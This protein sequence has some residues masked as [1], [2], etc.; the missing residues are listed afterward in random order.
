MNQW[1]MPGVSAAYM[2]MMIDAQRRGE[3][4]TDRIAQSES[5]SWGFKRVIQEKGI[6][7]AC[8]VYIQ[9]A[10]GA[11]EGSGFHLGGGVIAT[12]AHVAPVELQG[13]PHEIAIT[14]DGQNFMPAS[15]ALSEADFDAALLVAP[16]AKNI[17][18]VELADSDQVQTGDPIAVVSSP[19]GWR[20]TATVGIVSNVKQSLGQYAPTKAWAEDLIF[21]DADILQGSSGGA[22]FNESGQVIGSIMGVTGM[23]AEEGIGQRAVAPSNRLRHLLRTYLQAQGIHL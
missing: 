18:M 22:V 7:S 8:T 2:K 23:H 9:A 19:E 12:A 21:I 14:F 13:V 11:W 15:I 3:R 6:P 10:S 1:G 17:P 5:S 16:D 4:V 20:D